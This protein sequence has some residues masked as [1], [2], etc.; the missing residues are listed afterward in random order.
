MSLGI[1]GEERADCFTLIAF[2]YRLTVSVLC[3]FLAVPWVDLQCV[4][5]AFPSHTHLFE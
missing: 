5:V 3:L 2:E 1:R 4:V